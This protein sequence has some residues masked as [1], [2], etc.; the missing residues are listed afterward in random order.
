MIKKIYKELVIIL[1]VFLLGW[2]GF[3]FLKIEPEKPDLQISIEDEEKL[4][5]LLSLSIFSESIELHAPYL[6]EAM[7]TITKRLESHIDG[8][9]YEYKFHVIESENINAFATL[10]G[11]IFVHSA[12]IEA[13]E[14]PEELAAVLAHEI[15]HVEH[16][17]VVNKIVTEIGLSLLFTTLS[18]QDP[19]LIGEILEATVSNSFSRSHE[20]EADMYGLALMEKSQISPLYMAHVFRKLKEKSAAQYVPEILSTHPNINAR[21]QHALEAEVPEDFEAK[22]F[23][24]DWERVKSDLQKAKE[25]Q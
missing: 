1:S 4:A 7:F 20:K 2:I 9:P 24:I 21:I 10:G 11:N 18:G 8:T 13:V 16:R 3:T 25:A 14:N 12:L 5:E 15:G 22:N 19:V 6:D 17:H 23:D